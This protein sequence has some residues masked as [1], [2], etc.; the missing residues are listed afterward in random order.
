[1][2]VNEGRH[3]VSYAYA[4]SGIS[5]QRMP[6]YQIKEISDAAQVKRRSPYGWRSCTHGTS[7]HRVF[8][9]SYIEARPYAQ[10]SFLNFGI[11]FD[12]NS[13]MVEGKFAI[14][15]WMSGGNN[16]GTITAVFGFDLDPLSKSTLRLSLPLRL[17]LGRLLGASAIRRSNYFNVGDSRGGW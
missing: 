4:S 12:V 9:L 8:H 16:A 11:Q 14:E 13:K 3:S 2:T 15:Q 5:L 1:M 6:G 10:E 17:S 7:G